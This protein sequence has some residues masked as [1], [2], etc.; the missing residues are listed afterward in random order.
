VDANEAIKILVTA[1]HAE[2]VEEYLTARGESAAAHYAD[3]ARDDSLSEKGR[4]RQL[5]RAYLSH[6]QTVE[7]DLAD[8][9]A[10]VTRVDRGDAESVFVT[11]G[12]SGDPANL[13]IARRDADD[14]VASAEAHDL[15]AMLRRATRAGDEVMARAIVAR[16]VENGDADTVNQFTADRPDLQAATERLWDAERA[17][18][19][20]FSTNVLLAALRPGEL[21]RV[22][23]QDIEVLADTEPSEPAPAPTFQRSGHFVDQP[24]GHVSGDYLRTSE[25]G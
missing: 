11:A 10:R 18:T 20:T 4:T 24:A 8:R 16:A 17:Q 19:D 7:R 12:L 14:R 3:I 13:I 5:A 22:H 15:P 23:T 25:V 6:R 1:E 2:S 21:S 9:A